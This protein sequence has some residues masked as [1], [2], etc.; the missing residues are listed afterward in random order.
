MLNVKKT[1]T[2]VLEKITAHDTKITAHD[3]AYIVEKGTDGSWSYTKYSDH[4][5]EAVYNGGFAL[6]AGSAWAG[7]YYHKTTY[8]I[9]LPSWASSWTLKSAIKTDG[10]LMFCVGISA[11]SD[12]LHLVWQNGAAAAV[13][14]TSFGD[15]VTV[16]SGTWS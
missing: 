7:G 15:A 6:N 2:K 1:L 4:T 10:I 14:G 8:G 9:A 16:I 5:F 12:G 11:E 13:G 3:Y